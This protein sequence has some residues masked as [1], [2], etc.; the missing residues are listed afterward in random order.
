MY[1]NELARISYDEQR[2]IGS[3]LRAHLRTHK[4]QLRAMVAFGD[5]VTRGGTYDIDL[6]EVVEGWQGLPSIAFG[7]SADL[8]LRGL[9]RLYFLTPEEFEHPGKLVDA[10]KRRL[11]EQVQEGYTVI[12]EDPPLYAIETLTR[13]EPN[14]KS[15][16]PLNVLMSH[17]SRKA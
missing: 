7:S 2:A 17:G 4:G 6:L 13:P 16:N 12:Y 8:P 1:E 3:L 15:G 10:S 14:S 5:L 9:L 11:M